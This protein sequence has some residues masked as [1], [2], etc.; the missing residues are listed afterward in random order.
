MS[1][2]L[3]GGAVE[4]LGC[5]FT[6]FAFVVIVALVGNGCATSDRAEPPRGALPVE[7][8]ASFGT[9]TSP[10][11]DLAR[12]VH[13][14]REEAG[15]FQGGNLRTYEASVASSGAITVRARGSTGVTFDTISIGAASVRA[16][17]VAVTS[18]GRIVVDR[19]VVSER[20][21]GGE[22]GLE[23]A[24][25]FGAPPGVEDLEVRV[26]VGNAR[27]V[28]ETETGLHFAETGKSGGVVYGRA[29]WVDARP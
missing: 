20:I 8:G 5:A 10:S 29:T 4:K 1:G 17:S 7:S 21:D 24:W 23:Q 16:A 15:S 2:S 25:V 3:K 22:D 18:E 14:F 9:H 28:G 13:P 19:G 12:R 27:Y 26:R 11:I 6:L